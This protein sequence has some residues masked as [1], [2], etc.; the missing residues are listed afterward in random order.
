MK[1]R[2]LSKVQQRLCPVCDDRVHGRSDKIYCCSKCKDQDYAKQRKDYLITAKV[3]LG[4]L[5]RNHYLLDL[6]GG[7]ADHYT[8]SLAA[9]Q[10][11]GFDPNFITGMEQNK[12]GH[13]F[14]LFNYSWYPTNTQNIVV[15]RNKI[16]TPLSPYTYKRW[17]RHHER[18]AQTYVNTR[19][20]GWY[21][22]S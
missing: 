19:P 15:Y 22:P 7:D 8:I 20:E 3:V 6:F 2:N 16:E 18:F 21:G 14:K 9:L 13:K 1:N 12:Y 17:E 11:K 4:Q 10:E 5:A